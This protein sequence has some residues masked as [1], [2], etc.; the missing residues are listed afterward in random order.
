MRAISRWA[1][2]REL[3]EMGGRV[4]ISLERILYYPPN[5]FRCAAIR[6][7]VIRQTIIRRARNEQG[8]QS[9]Y[10]GVLPLEPLFGELELCFFFFPDLWLAPFFFLPVVLGVVVM[11]P[12]VP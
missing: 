12:P 1:E 8:S 7:A 10:L 9:G 3:S 6:R 11:S 2:I 5:H 4:A